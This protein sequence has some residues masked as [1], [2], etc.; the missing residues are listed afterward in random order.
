MKERPILFSGP[1]VRAIL[2]GR[3]V[4]TRRVVVPQPGEAWCVPPVS[5]IAGRW[6][7]AG[8]ISDL[9]C[10]YGMTGDRLWVR[11][12]WAHALDF[13][14]ATGQAFYRAT[15][16]NGGVFDDVKTWKPSIFMPRWASR[17]ALEVEGVRVERVQDIPCADIF[18][19]GVECS[20]HRNVGIDG[21]HM[22]QCACRE[23]FVKLWDSIN[24]PRG[25][26][27]SVNP[28]VWVISFRRV[29]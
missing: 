23:L 18:R 5:V 7:S 1:M 8:S 17:I 21:L 12:T 9:R 26:G 10:P 25:F 16:T 29:S 11:E 13:G 15:Y 28:W 4:M 3:K 6:V 27:W 2:D 24:G 19:E 22:D 20:M 14:H